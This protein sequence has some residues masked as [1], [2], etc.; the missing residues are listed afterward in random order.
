MNQIELQQLQD[1]YE[2]FSDAPNKMCTFHSKETGEVIVLIFNPNVVGVTKLKDFLTLKADS[3]RN[4]V[5]WWKGRDIDT[6]SK[7]Y[8]LWRFKKPIAFRIDAAV[9]T[10][11]TIV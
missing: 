9:T 1:Q 7:I 3:L 2:P 5:F 10:Q 8:S 11:K 6:L 4:V